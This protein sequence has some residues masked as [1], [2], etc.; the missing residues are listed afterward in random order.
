MIDTSKALEKLKQDLK[1]IFDLDVVLTKEK[2]ALDTILF[3]PEEMKC[4]GSVKSQITGRLTVIAEG[5]KMG[6]SWFYK[7]HSVKSGALTK[8]FVFDKTERFAP[9]FGSDSIVEASLS[10]TYFYEEQYNKEV[11]KLEGL[12]TTAEFSASM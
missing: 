4:T 3:T 12:T 10:F 6:L 2:L 8:P 9:F 5:E 11:R 7:R 1:A